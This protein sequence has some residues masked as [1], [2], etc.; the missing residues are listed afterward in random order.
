MHTISHLGT[1][2]GGKVANSTNNIISNSYNT[3]YCDYVF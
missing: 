2:G 1:A 3:L